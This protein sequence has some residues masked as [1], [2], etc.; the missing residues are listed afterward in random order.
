[1]QIVYVLKAVK[2]ERVSAEH[3]STDLEWLTELMTSYVE[4]GYK[5]SLTEHLND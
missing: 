2:D 4:K 3:H 1:M 5:V